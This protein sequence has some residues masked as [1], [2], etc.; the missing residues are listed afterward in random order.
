MRRV[1]VLCGF[2]ALPV[3]AAVYLLL[4][5]V[6]IEPGAWT[7]PPAPPLEGPY[8][9]NSVLS[10]IERVGDHDGPAPED[11]VNDAAGN[12]YAGCEDGRIL[13]WSKDFSTVKEFVNTGGRPLGLQFDRYGN[14]IVADA[15]KGLLLV[16]PE[17]AIT[18]L[19]TECDGRPF[20]FVDDLAVTREL[21]VYFTDASSKFSFREYVEDLMEHQPNGRLLSYSMVTRKTKLE[22]D[23]LYFANGVAL[24]PEEDFVLVSETGKYRVLRYWIKG[25]RAGETEV[26]IDNLPGF[27][28]NIAPGS[29][30]RYWLALATPRDAFLDGLLPL[31]GLRKVLAR[32]P[33]FLQPGPKRYSFVLGL[34]GT[35]KVLHNLQDPAG[36]YAPI[37][38]AHEYDGKLYFG[39]I[40]E[41]AVGRIAVPAAN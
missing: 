22:L 29:G 9:V 6:K 7:P 26:F 8:A 14:L 28:D 41:P 23:G 25:D 33:R 19:S 15:V 21:V 2:G 38:S 30:G 17:G 40:L 5:P 1:A 16:N 31:P 34:D 4:A 13:R 27:P 3:A 11:V 18:V 39:S 32:L 10:A 36:P 24:S 37:T 35:G 12:L 20:R